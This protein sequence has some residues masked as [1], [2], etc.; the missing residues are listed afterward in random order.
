MQKKLRTT[1]EIKT[2]GFLDFETGKVYQRKS[3][4]T[5]IVNKRT[6][7]QEQEKQSKESL[8]YT[9]ALNKLSSKYKVKKLS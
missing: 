6:A 9:T 2:L 4:R 1:V 7:E 5:R 3:D 8:A